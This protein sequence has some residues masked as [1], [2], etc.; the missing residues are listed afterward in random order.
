VDCSRYTIANNLY[1]SENNN[2]IFAPHITTFYVI[3]DI[4]INISFLSLRRF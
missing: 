2:L 3:Y 4:V 1:K